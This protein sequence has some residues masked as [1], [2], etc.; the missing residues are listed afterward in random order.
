MLKDIKYFID[1]DT[2]RQEQLEVSWSHKIKENRL[3]SLD[4]FKQTMPNIYQVLKVKT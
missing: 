3:A 4:V 2:E 1:Q